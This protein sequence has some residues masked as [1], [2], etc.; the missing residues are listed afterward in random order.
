[1]IL[2]GLVLTLVEAHQLTQNLISFDT[3]SETTWLITGACLLGL[4]VIGGFIALGAAAIV[5]AV[6][7]R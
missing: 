4:G 1:M 7:E 2:V 5:H 3:V 6:R